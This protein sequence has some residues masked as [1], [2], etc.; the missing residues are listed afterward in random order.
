[1]LPIFLTSYFVFTLCS[2]FG[3]NAGSAVDIYNTDQPLNLPA[4]SSAVV[5]TALAGS[6]A[7]LVALF[8]N[9]FIQERILGEPM[10]K[11]SAAMNGCLTGLSAVTGSCA[12]IEPWAAIVIGL[13]AGCVYLFSSHLLVKFRLDDAVDAIPVHLFGGCWGLIA[14]AFF[15]SPRGLKYYYGLGDESDVAHVGAFYSWGQG[16]FDLNMLACQLIG[17]VF[18][19]GWTTATMLPF[20]LFLSYL[21]ILRSDSFEELV[22]LDV[23]YHGYTP[24]V[25]GDEIGK[26][27]LNTYLK[28]TGKYN[29]ELNPEEDNTGTD[30]FED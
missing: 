2:W 18:I 12:F 4:I 5:N 28:R 30:R 27:Q 25:V 20:F 3:F 17:I 19:L 7:G 6:S 29:L 11:L 16:S 24:R 10:F 14:T 1:M 21:G 15:A 9:L 8:L 26:D 13:V 23:S 22:G